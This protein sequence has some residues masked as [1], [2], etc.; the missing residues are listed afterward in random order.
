LQKSLPHE[1]IGPGYSPGELMMRM[2]LLRP[3]ACHSPSSPSG[4]RSAL[5]LLFGIGVAMIYALATTKPVSQ[6]SGR[7]IST[8]AD[9]IAI[10]QKIT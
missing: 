6:F 5:V 9:Y 2:S 1:A 10:P 7:R 8:V 4:G 3:R